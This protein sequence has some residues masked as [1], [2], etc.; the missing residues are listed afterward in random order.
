M[1]NHEPAAEPRG[2]GRPV[3]PEEELIAKIREA[4]L[5]LLL[6]Q[7]YSAMT[8]DAVAKR[9]GV[10][11][12]TL[13]RFAENREDLAEQI[14]RG[15]TD[16]FVP[17]FMQDAENKDDFYQLLEKNLTIMSHKVLSAEAAGLFC[18]LSSEFPGRELLLPRYQAGGIERGRALLAEWLSRHQDFLSQTD[19]AQISDLL[20][21][22]V[23]AEPLR[24]IALKLA[25]PVPD[26]PIEPRIRAAV[27]LL[28]C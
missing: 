14:V 25:P 15:W 22:M 3:V 17:L 26:Y 12:K 18:L 28:K 10:S 16:S 5:C 9:A 27:A 24:Q 8:M 4:S 13:Y 11:K 23:M 19:T 1:A 20:L 2:R 21:S 7:G 6:S